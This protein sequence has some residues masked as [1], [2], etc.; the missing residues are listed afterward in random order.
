MRR[1]YYRSPLGTLVRWILGTGLL[2]LVMTFF[3]WVATVV[4]PR[5]APFL[6]IGV[7]V[8]VAIWAVDRF[9]G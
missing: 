6:L 2:F 5:I 3:S 1:H 7:L 9:R 4:L 8:V